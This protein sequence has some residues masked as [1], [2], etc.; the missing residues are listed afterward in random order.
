MSHHEIEE[1]LGAYALDAVDVDEARTVEVHLADCPR[2]RAEVEAHRE[3][4]ALLSSGTT[5]AVPDGVWDRIAAD[6][7]DTPPPVPIEVASGTRRAERTVRTDRRD[8]PG[9]LLLGLAAAA[10][11]VII[12]LMGAVLVNQRNDLD[13]LQGEVAAAQ[14]DAALTALVGDPATRVVDLEGDATQ[15][16]AFVGQ[17]GQSVLVADGLPTLDGNRTYQLWGLPE[18]SEDM[19]SLG[20]LGEDPNESEFRVES[21]ITTLA[22][23]DEPSGGSP[24]PTADPLVVGTIA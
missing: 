16:R 23:T 9:R 20:L 7:G 19:V 3:V 2:C 15:A 6:L 11:V 13:D 10:V 4:A 8:G 1:L 24:E 21:E 18:G 22:I 17:D 5:T 14:N 12:A